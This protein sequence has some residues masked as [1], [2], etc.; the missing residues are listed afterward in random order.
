MFEWAKNP[1]PDL[2]VLG[3]TVEGAPEHVWIEPTT[4]CNT[5]CAHCAHFYEQFGEDMPDDQ[6]RRIFDAV[7]EDTRR[8]ELIGY[9]EPFVS[10]SFDLI[11]DECARRGI[12]IFITTNGLKL[13]DEAL[14]E[15]L[16]R[17]GTRLTVSVDGGAQGIL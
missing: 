8:A 17:A 3:E 15:R 11:F 16:V 5:R 14:V 13:R 4:R 2:S 10:R 7:I 12:E 1:Y 9:G 6:A